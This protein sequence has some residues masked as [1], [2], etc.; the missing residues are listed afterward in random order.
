[1]C[2][3][4]GVALG[5]KAM[6]FTLQFTA[7]FAVVID[8][9]VEHHLNAAVFVRDR[10]IPCREVDDTQAPVSEGDRTVDQRT[11][12][13]RTPV[14]DLVTHGFQDRA[15][16]RRSVRGQVSSDSTHNGDLIAF[17]F[18]R[19]RRGGHGFGLIVGYSE[20][21]TLVALQ[22]G[23]DPASDLLVWFP[24]TIDNSA[25]GSFVQVKHLREPVLT[26]AAHPQLQ[27]E[28]WIHTNFPGLLLKF[29]VEA[30]AYAGKLRPFTHI[31]SCK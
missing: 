21:P 6:S 2:Q 4:F 18:D 24:E 7:E 23:G 28:I 11:I 29:C 10:L 25:E 17:P 1:M 30:K 19:Q 14:H 16:R 12:S 15:I 8:L 5:S 31:K 27:F 26:N 22:K 3:H 9:T 13:I 20:E